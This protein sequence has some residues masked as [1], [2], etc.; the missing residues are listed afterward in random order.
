QPTGPRNFRKVVEEALAAEPDG[1]R[2]LIH[3]LQDGL[4]PAEM[5]G[6]Q[7]QGGPVTQRTLA[8]SAQTHGDLVRRTEQGDDDD[9]KRRELL[10]DVSPERPSEHG[11]WVFEPRDPARSDQPGNEPPAL[12]E[13]FIRD[14][15]ALRPDPFPIK[16]PGQNFL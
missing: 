7:I 16:K 6:D 9:P 15:D 10:Q 4:H 11:P 3:A 13:E 12:V 8:A 1:S 2:G 14:L 5:N